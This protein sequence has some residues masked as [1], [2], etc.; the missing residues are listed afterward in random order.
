MDQTPKINVSILVLRDNKT[1]LGL[2]SDKWLFNGK[3]VYGS[4]GRDIL[5]GETMGDAIK[6]NIKEDIDCEVTNYSIFC[7][8]ANYEWGNHYIGIGAT[9]NIAGNP[10]LLHP[11]DWD[12]WEWFDL[13]SL[14]LNLLPELQYLLKCYR[15][16]K[17]NVSE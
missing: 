7:I 5:F 16:K 14:P 3:K 9:A 17:V 6:R 4:P 10:K 11:D 15:E 13:Q 1:L 2:L 8:N 12:T